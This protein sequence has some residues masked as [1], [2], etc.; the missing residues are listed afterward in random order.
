MRSYF[1][2]LGLVLWLA[3]AAEANL[4]V[5]YAFPRDSFVPSTVAPHVSA[6]PI[7]NT[8]S[9]ASLEPDNSEREG[10]FLRT[11]VQSTTP[12][13]AVANSQF[14]AF[15]VTPEAGFMLDL[16][17]LTFVVARGGPS[18]PRGFVLRSSL[19][20]FA[21][22]IATELVPT[23]DPT[24]TGFSLELTGSAFQHIGSATTFRIYGF[25][26]SAQEGLY[27]GD[28]TLSGQVPEPASCA[29]V[30]TAALGLIGYRRSR[31]LG[32]LA[33]SRA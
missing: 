24:F 27:F 17:N 14:F 2:V 13:Q 26:P 23:Q 19:D 4:I 3:H 20:N 10:M 25:T 12:A 6:T 7:N 15:S 29:C 21:A 18:T 5:H 11:L 30:G 31:K 9:A 1:A 22:D 32:S 33:K 8:G 28:I 16:A